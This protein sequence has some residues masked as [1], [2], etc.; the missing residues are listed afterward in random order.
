MLQ[1]HRY[2]EKEAT[3]KVNEKPLEIGVFVCTDSELGIVHKIALQTKHNI[4][5]ARQSL[6]QAVPVGKRMEED[7]VEVVVS[8]GATAFFLRNHVHI[9]V[10][11]FPLSSLDILA[12]VRIA[13]GMGHKIFMPQFLSERKGIESIGELL[14]VEVAQG[15]YTDTS[16][17]QRLLLHAVRDGFS[18]VIG[19]GAARHFAAELD[20]RYCGFVSAEEQMLETIDN[21]QSV[22][23]SER[24]RKAAAKHYQTVL[25]A[26]SDG[27]IATN[28]NGNVTAVNAAAKQILNLPEDGAVNLLISRLI[29]HLPSDSISRRGKTIR[30]HVVEIGRETLVFNHIPVLMGEDVIGVVTFVRDAAQE[31]RVE[32][33]VRRTRTKG[34]SARYVIDDLIHRHPSMGKVADLCRAFAKTDSSVLITGE[35][36]TGKEIVAESIHNL[37]GR[38]TWPFVSIQCGALQE[39][40]LESELFGYEEGA[41]TGSRK[42]GKP[43]LFE[44]AH[45][46]TIFLDEIDSAPISVQLRLLRVLQEKEVMRLGSEQILP[47][48]VRVI[49]ASGRNL[50]E[51]VR[52]G[53]F[54][55]DLFFRLNVLHISVPP[56]R[57]RREDIPRLLR[58]FLDRYRKQYGLAPVVLPDSYVG[59]L[60]EY[61]WPGNVRQLMHFAE[62]LLLK[63]GNGCSEDVLY[64]LFDELKR[65]TL[66]GK[67]VGERATGAYSGSSESVVQGY[68]SEAK[69]IYT[70][71]EK[72]RFHKSRTART[73]GI[74]RV[75]LWRKMKEHGL[76]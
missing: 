12:S 42:G 71:L 66:L 70:A 57:E 3:G 65:I 11:S 55:K 31:M 54:R 68:S 5:I 27:I 28:C 47:V 37:S 44:L 22:A 36:G 45:Q 69:Q 21:A 63:R 41:F 56:L 67:D 49:V 35:T 59:R 61:S 40:L 76:S 52:E 53:T 24:K 64:E 19:G 32:N 6:E 13:A 8:R 17:F 26:S 20:I 72:C 14:G 10:L 75:T 60:M 9:P 33:R 39:Q 18:V 4:R 46:G 74:S 7:G 2:V 51:A 48:D 38:R 50:W 73:L 15:T 29:P 30:N 23:L 1:S 62:L 43:G 25:D 58:H 34:F 16:Q